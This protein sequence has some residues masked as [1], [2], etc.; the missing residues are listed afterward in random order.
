MI[1]L[2]RNQKTLVGSFYSSIS[3]HESFNQVIKHYKKGEID[4]RALIER[5]YKLEEINEAFDDL[6]EGQDGRGII[7]FPN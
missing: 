2:C 4:I 3:P 1:D 5:T 7:I 6:I